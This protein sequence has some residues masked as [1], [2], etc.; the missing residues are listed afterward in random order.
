M[1]PS[2][3]PI[4]LSMCPALRVS[5]WLNGSF[6]LT[7][8]PRSYHGPGALNLKRHGVAQACPLGIEPAL[9]SGLLLY[10]Q[11]QQVPSLTHLFC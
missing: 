11:L 6:T 10:G 4:L 3:V 9:I 1:G 5:P 7:E 8:V 2:S